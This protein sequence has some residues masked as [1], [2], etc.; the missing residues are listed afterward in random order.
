MLEQIE[1]ILKSNWSSTWFAN[2]TFISPKFQNNEPAVNLNKLTETLLQVFMPFGDNKTQSKPS[3]SSFSS[4]SSASNE[5]SLRRLFVDQIQLPSDLY[6]ELIHNTTVDR[7][8]LYNYYLEEYPAILSKNNNKPERIRLLRGA[9]CNKDRFDK[10][11]QLHAN[12]SADQTRLDKERMRTHMCNM[13][14][15]QI[16]QLDNILADQF[17][18]SS[19]SS[20]PSSP[21]FLADLENQM[22]DYVYFLSALNDLAKLSIHFP[23]GLC[24][25]KD[26][27]EILKESEDK[28]HHN[29]PDP[30]INEN[31]INGDK[32]LKNKLKKNHGFIGLW[33]SM[34]K[35]FCGASSPTASISSNKTS[36]ETSAT[37]ANT[38]NSDNQDELSDLLSKDQLKSLSLIY[39]V[40][41]SNPIILFSPNTSLIRENIIKKTNSTFEMIDKINIFCRQWLA[42]SGQLVEFIQHEKTNRS[43]A[44][45]NAFKEL[46]V[47]RTLMLLNEFEITTST[48]TTTTTTTNKKDQVGEFDMFQTR[49]F[50]QLPDKTMQQDL[51]IKIDMIDSAACSW[52]SLMSGVNLDLFKGFASEKDLVNYFLNN[53]YSDNATVIAS[54]VF[55]PKNA[56][57]TEYLDQHLVYK[58][59]QNASFTYTTKKVRERYWY[60]SPRDW[61]Y[62][63]YLFGFVWLQDLIDRAI[64]DYHSN[65]T[66]LEPGSYIHQMPFHCYIHDNFLQMVQHVM[67]LCLSVS[68]VYTVAMLT[69]TMVYEKE[70][71][72]KEVMKIMGLNNVVHLLAWFITYFIQ[73]SIIMAVI[74]CILHFGQ[75]L[76]HSN[77]VLIFI[78]LE[79]Y[80]TATICFSFLVSSL[81]SKAKLAAACAGILY[82]LSYVPCMFISIREDG[83]ALSL[84]VY[85]S[86]FFFFLFF[87]QCDSR[88]RK[89]IFFLFFAICAILC[90]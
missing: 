89:F 4:S 37:N 54:V 22:R 87:Y 23:T 68:F 32:S 1:T 27:D 83:K 77:P 66:I 49:L 40:M 69:Q 38:T 14:M 63:Y 85:L 18:T 30:L 35:T 33:Y 8:E 36:S 21:N 10:I 44:T 56:S 53:A 60:P 42:T 9:F 90:S 73:F 2:N 67:P 19:P 43:L 17:L 78:L 58:I 65:S 48:T 39:H 45:L 79:I 50:K 16:D 15:D 34:Q 80:A 47:N 3:S 28:I 25:S 46:S 52:L 24:K 5:A 57:E 75:I 86:S 88:I 59:R 62:Y 11:L 64:V 13:S 70:M 12:K 72:L 20:P 31:T 7:S 71:R 84:F 61:D 74:T 82:F 29:K 26:P 76:S 81:Y 6:D 55:Q 51:L 41:Y